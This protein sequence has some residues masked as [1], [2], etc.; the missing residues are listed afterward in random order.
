[1]VGVETPVEAAART[2]MALTQMLI[3]SDLARSIPFYRDILGATVL[4]EGEPSIPALGGGWL[5]LNVGGPRPR[6]SPA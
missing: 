3:V 5:V 1:M 4:R 6:T 2:G